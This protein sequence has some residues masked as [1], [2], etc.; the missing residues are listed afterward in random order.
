MQ[1]GISRGGLAREGDGALTNPS[2]RSGEA[3][4]RLIKGR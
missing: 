3:R 4:G 1:I 2:G